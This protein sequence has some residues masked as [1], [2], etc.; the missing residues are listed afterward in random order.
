VTVYYRLHGNDLHKHHTNSE[1]HVHP[2]GHHLRTNPKI[3]ELRQQLQDRNKDKAAAAAAPLLKE[4]ENNETLQLLDELR[5]RPTK[6]KQLQ[7][8]PRNLLTTE[9]LQ[10][11]EQ[12]IDMRQLNFEL[13]FD[14]PDG[15]AWKQGWDVAPVDL[16]DDPNSHL[17]IF[18][19]PHSHCD[20]GWIKTFDEYFRQQTTQIITTI[21][22]AL[23]QDAR[24][25]FIWAEISY[26]SWWWE[27]QPASMRAAVREL[28]R[29]GQLEFVTG[30]WVQPDEANSELY[31]MEI[32]LQEG[33]DW[34]RS[35]VGAEYIPRYG[36]AIDPFGYSPTAAYLWKQYNFTGMLIQRVHY[37][38]K[39]R[40][41]Q[42]RHLE[43]Y[44]R[45][46][47]DN[48]TTAVDDVNGQKVAPHDIFTHVMPFFSYDVPHTCGPDPAVCCQFD[49]ARLPGKGPKCPWHQAPQK[50]TD[51][52]VQQRALLLL[53]QYRKKAALYRSNALLAPLGDDFR[54]QIPH[55]A[56]A[57]YTNYQKIFD[58]INENVPGVN[59]QFGTL[60]DYFRAAR[61]TFQGPVPVLKGSFFTYS[62]VDQDYWSGYFT[63]R[64]FDK[65][66]DR[67]LERI[68]YAAES[69]SGA[70]RGE[71]QV[72][73]RALSLFQH[74][75]GVTGTAKNKVVQDYAQRMYDAIDFTQNWIRQDSEA[76]LVALVGLDLPAIHPC[77]VSTEPREMLQNFCDESSTVAVYN[78]LPTEQKCGD[79]V[80]PGRTFAGA[81][82]PC[83]VPGPVLSST[84]KTEFVF[85]QKT[86][87]LLEPVKEEWR[88]WQVRKGGAYLF[89]PHDQQSYD[90]AADALEIEQGGFVVK[91]HSWN[92]TIVEKVVPTEFG[93][94]ATIIDFIYEIN[95]STVNQE[96]FVR[97]SAGIQNE[98]YFHT[99]LNGFD[100]DT[101]RF[102]K[103]LPI[104]SQVFP[105]PTLASIQDTRLRMS[106]LSEHAQGTASLQDGA[107]DVWLDRRLAQ[108]DNRGLGQGVLDNRRTRTRLRVIL[109]Q[110]GFNSDNSAEF[111]VTSLGRQMWDELQ[112]PLVLFGKHKAEFQAAAERA[113]QQVGNAAIS[114]TNGKTLTRKA[115]K[116]LPVRNVTCSIH[117]VE[118]TVVPF[119][120]MVYKRLD[121]LK[122]AI[123]SLRKSDFPRDRV[124]LVISHDGHV[125]EMIEYAKSLEGEFEL[126][127]LVHEHS[128]YDHKDTFPGDDPNLN[129]GYKGD[130][131]GNPRE[132]WVTCCK[133]HFTWMIKTVFTMDY[134]KTKNVDTFLF[135]E[136]D[137]LVAP[138][139]YQA[140]AGGL[141]AMHEYEGETSG[142]FLGV[143]LTSTRKVPRGDP[144][145]WYGVAFTSGPMTL[146]RSTFAKIRLHAPE[147]CG[148][149]GFD[150]Y[151]W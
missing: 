100:F 48:A 103:D 136:E 117:S 27:E 56:E 52:N 54:Y 150:E 74:H 110:D 88:F 124:P 1:N 32:Q 108:D 138:T 149:D 47:W 121:Y 49:F 129:V 135:L 23:L 58:Y 55:E 96:W 126:V 15:G 17:Q 119:V 122:M 73:R 68:L 16:S 127:Q 116:P 143:G 137:Y 33:H 151:N 125:P 102:R 22:N 72:P 139:I 133:H 42:E 134:F 115:P 57:Q 38:V 64:V 91:T 34:I 112:H 3:D 80:V 109:E 111:N 84:R 7:P 60:S 18:V 104:Q 19:V 2:L 12:V 93:T 6:A 30:G 5:K 26:F 75:D 142:G 51:A 95:L 101:H 67:Q 120:F 63:S 144:D 106:V 89:V 35:A 37:A 69:M 39:K 83:E 79:A 131:Y 92:R 107:I 14:N 45:Q 123:E 13:P 10:L 53:D 8:P 140:L 59:I 147:F 86:G 113:A 118:N 21:V 20:P 4:P 25:T 40:L 24:R 90:L 50:I 28:L 44:W 29:T 98:G 62:D 46:T 82:L 36:W 97:F 31:A 87:L 105:M 9:Q 146:D 130:L 99:D 141:N 41:A 128:C 85:D 43:F 71:L 70:T 145:A 78:P 132:A 148:R 77:W 61:G 66:L 11:P 81:K 65:A 114:A 76:Y 94:T